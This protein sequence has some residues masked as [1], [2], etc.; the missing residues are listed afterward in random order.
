MSQ[1]L[2]GTASGIQDPLAFLGGPYRTLDDRDET[3]RNIRLIIRVRWF[4]SPAVLLL[5]L[6]TSLAGLSRRE[7]FTLD[8]L[9]VNGINTLSVM[10]LNLLYARLVRRARDVRPL[11]YLQLFVDI[12]SFSLT[13]YKTGG[14]ASPLSFL[15][16]GVIFA[17]ALLVSG[18]ASF[19]TAAISALLFSLVVVLEN[20][21]LLPHQDYFIPLSGLPRSLAYQLLTWIVKVS[22]LFVMALLA[23]F[24][25]LEIR[26]KHARLR[27]A[28]EVLDRK[29]QTLLLLYRTAKALSAHRTVRAVVDT[30]LSELLE[31]LNLDRA[32]LYLNVQDRYLHLYRVRWRSGIP[33][34]EDAQPRLD[35]PLRMEAGLTA[36]CALE[37]RPYN[38]HHP[39]RSELINRELAQRIGMNPFAIAPLVVRDKLIGVLGIDRSSKNGW[40]TED[41]FQILQIFA[42][43]AALTLSSLLID[44]QQAKEIPSTG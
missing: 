27:E 20:R 39:E 23:A 33:A 1:T 32:L 24:L 36:R 31:F 26:R 41:E 44:P 40:I 19:L 10:G 34:S 2:S 6:V 12:L 14:A 29:I 37:K 38:I 5:L 7:L 9:L 22:S 11:I 13:V 8:Q 16:F 42:H 4:V 18:R 3:L 25:T 35:I 17:A 30:I 15:Y 21:G 43:Q 28:N